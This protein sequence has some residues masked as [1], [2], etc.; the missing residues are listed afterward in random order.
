MGKATLVLSGKGPPSHWTRCWR[1]PDIFVAQVSQ[2]PDPRIMSGVGLQ[3]SNVVPVISLRRSRELL[4]LLLNARDDGASPR[5]AVV[6]VSPKFVRWPKPREWLRKKKR[7]F[8]ETRRVMEW[9]NGNHLLAVCIFDHNHPP[10]DT[11]WSG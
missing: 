5:S 1:N 9:R 3:A 7:V 11:Q 2:N 8:D 10:V 4:A 6:L